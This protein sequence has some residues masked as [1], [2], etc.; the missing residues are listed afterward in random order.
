[1]VRHYLFSTSSM[2]AS[3]QHHSEL[4][5]LA[6]SLLQFLELEIYFHYIFLN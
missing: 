4:T 6:T 3:S 5:M 1:M 2:L